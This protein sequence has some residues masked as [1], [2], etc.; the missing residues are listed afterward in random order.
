MSSDNL[1][2][3]QVETCTAYVDIEAPPPDGEPTA[4]LLFGT[5]QTQPVDIVAERYHKGLAPLI[6][7]T[8]GVNRHNGI[9]EGR[10]FHRL[11]VERGVPEA[12]IRYEDTSCNT[13]QNVEFSLPFLREALASGLRITAIGKWYHRRTLHCLTTLLPD[14]GPFYGI[15]WEPWYAG[16]LVTRTEWPHIPDGKRRVI[17]EWE[18]VSRRVADGSFR[19]AERVAGAWRC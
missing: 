1:S 12:A 18:E 8:G 4:H 13:W 3:E 15:S 16:K 6:I 5:N 10:E 14:I 2:T 17:R 19:A 9:I 11:L 7:A